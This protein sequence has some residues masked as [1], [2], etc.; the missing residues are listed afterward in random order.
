MDNNLNIQDMKTYLK[1]LFDL[2]S[3]IFLN[4]Q[5]METYVQNR[6]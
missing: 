6:N 2:E 3:A 4:D 5:M 1:T